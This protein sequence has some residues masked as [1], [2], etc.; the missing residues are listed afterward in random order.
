MLFYQ[1]Y[2][3]SRQL[4]M[5]V[6]SMVLKLY[7]GHK[8]CSGFTTFGG[9]ESILLSVLAHK[10]WAK[11]RGLTKFE[12]IFP[13]T[14][15]AAFYKACDFFDVTP[16]VIPINKKTYK[17]RVEDFEK[18]ITPNTIM[19][20]ASCPNLSYGIIDPVKAINNLAG[21]HTVGL[22]L[23]CCMGGFLLPFREE[24]GIEQ[25]EDIVDF[26]LSNVTA[27]VC[28]PHKYGMVPKGCSVLMF[29]NQDIQKA[30]YYGLINWCG[31]IYGTTIFTGS[32]ASAPIAAAW[33]VMMLNG[34]QGYLRNAK[35]INQATEKLAKAVNEIEGI[36][37]I[38][39]PKIGNIG[40]RSVNPKLKIYSLGNYL[41][42][43]GWKIPATPKYPCLRLTIHPNNV[44]HLEELAKLMKKGVEAVNTSN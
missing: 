15:H 40:F 13:E 42:K 10:R 8:Q 39:N 25:E 17:V 3:R 1:Q 14:A 24:L 18:R 22:M 6:V 43:N 19:M 33:A 44:P 34:R 21:K 27:I 37:T 5:E 16:I 32:R 20:V 4:E 2:P 9:S 29:G 26:R 38:G 36:E 23:D 41:H 28:D 35:S 31:Y 30:L 7:N 12:V 11:A